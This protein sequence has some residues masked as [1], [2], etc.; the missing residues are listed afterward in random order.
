MHCMFVHELFDTQHSIWKWWGCTEEHDK[1][2]GERKK[3]PKGRSHPFPLHPSPR[4]AVQ[5][6]GQPAN[7]H[8]WLKACPLQLYG[9]YI[10]LNFLITSSVDKILAI[11]KIDSHP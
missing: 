2:F 4:T 5:N 7:P 11:G 8:P 9:M 1:L 6:N 3:N 10:K